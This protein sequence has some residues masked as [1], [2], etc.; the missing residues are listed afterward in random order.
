[1]HVFTD[2]TLPAQPMKHILPAL[3]DF[4]IA[5]AQN[6]THSP[7]RLSQDIGGGDLRFTIG[8][9]ERGYGF[10]VYDT[11]GL[12]QDDQLVAAWDRQDGRLTALAVGTALGALRTGAIGGLASAAMAPHD[13]PVRVGL[14]GTGRQA[15][16]Q[17]TALQALRQIADLR[18]WSP[19]ARNCARFAA[20]HDATAMPGA[21]ETVENADVVILAT[22]AARPVID[23]GWIAPHAHVTTV[24]PK[25]RTRHEL[26]LA[27]F[28]T[29]A[30]IAT[31]SPGQITS[32]NTH[33][34]QGHPALDRLTH[35]GAILA[36][37]IQRPKGQ[38]LFLS[39]GLAG[40]EVA[41]LRALAACKN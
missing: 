36:G 29:A 24:G 3:R 16:T 8:G 41:A 15:T 11:L 7:A 2:T 5:A 12:P 17:I 18:V 28:D 14:I 40:T 33:M 1:M 27:L 9:D 38:S 26:P 25:T 4:I 30:V 13:G 22:S 34:L 35:L 10:R 23:P 6:A 32:Q 39:A 20:A 19:T 31:D 21:R 37:T